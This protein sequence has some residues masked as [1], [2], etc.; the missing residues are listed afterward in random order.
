MGEFVFSRK[1]ATWGTGQQ[2]HEGGNDY[3]GGKRSPVG[4]AEK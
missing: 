3:G 1:H 4:G 2:D